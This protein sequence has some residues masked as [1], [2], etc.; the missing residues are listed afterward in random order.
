[1]LLEIGI[2]IRTFCKDRLMV[3]RFVSGFMPMTAA[4]RPDA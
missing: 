1:V 2:Q 4:R 3:G